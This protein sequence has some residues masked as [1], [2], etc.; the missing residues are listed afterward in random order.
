MT[1]PRK[2]GSRAKR[3]PRMRADGTNRS[4]AHRGKATRANNDA[5]QAKRGEH[6][7][8]P[9]RTAARKKNGALA[10]LREICLALPEATEQLFGGHTTPTWRVRDKI[11]VMLS[12]DEGGS[13]WC[14]APPGAQAVLVG[15][16]PDRFFSPRYVGPK[17]WVGIRL[18]NN[19]DWHL[20]QSLI[21]D[22]YH[23]TAPK[24]LAAQLH[25]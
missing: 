21:E 15:G 13:V 2:P 1:T 7:T 18:N 12:E 14:K 24:R 19:P 10:R 9:H 17:G 5:R 20:V 6:P 11:F 23:L 25:S 3:D 8:T 4:P 22:S 16:D